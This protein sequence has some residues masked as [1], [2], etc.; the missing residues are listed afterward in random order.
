MRRMR[1]RGWMIDLFLWVCPLIGVA[2]L[3][4]GVLA[5]RNLAPAMNYGGMHF[6]AVPGRAWFGLAIG[7]LLVPFLIACATRRV[8]GF[9]AGVSLILLLSVGV[10]WLRSHRASDRISLHS[11]AELPDGPWFTQWTLFSE[12]GGVAIVRY[13]WQLEPPIQRLRQGWRSVGWDLG[14]SHQA[15]PPEADYPAGRMDPVPASPLMRRL[16]FALG[17]HTE[18]RRMLYG[19]AVLFPLALPYWFICLLA[20]PLPLA[21]A[22]RY[23]RRRRALRRA[24]AGQCVRCGYDLRA[25]P[26]AGGARLAVCPECG[27]SA[28]ATASA[29]PSAPTLSRHSEEKR[30]EERP[31]IHANERE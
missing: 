17:R 13:R 18:P 24:L 26:D 29:P 6:Y 5:G 14:I 11:F 28:G 20:T 7:A 15:S 12:S 8:V 30:K 4:G 21:W 3:I 27:A 9:L 2:G 25:T 10:A 23:R 19:A 31:R 1:G 16:G 22:L